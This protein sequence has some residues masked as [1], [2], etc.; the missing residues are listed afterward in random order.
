MANL[1]YDF[2]NKTRQ[3]CAYGVVMCRHK[4]TLLELGKDHV[5]ATNGSVATNM[6]RNCP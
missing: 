3:L 1:F 4:T 2:H 5:L 6:D